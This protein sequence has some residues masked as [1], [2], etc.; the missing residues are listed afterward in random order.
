MCNHSST[1]ANAG[2]RMIH[3]PGACQGL[4]ALEEVAPAAAEAGLVT[5]SYFQLVAGERIT[6][7]AVGCVP[8]DSVTA[9]CLEASSSSGLDFVIR[10]GKLAD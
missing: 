2:V 6:E 4:S 5:N 7:R 10:F 1:A 3:S 9:Q 8:L